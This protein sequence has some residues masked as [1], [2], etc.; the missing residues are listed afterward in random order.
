LGHALYRGQQIF[1]IFGT[2]GRYA[3]NLRGSFVENV[4]KSKFNPGGGVM[5]IFTL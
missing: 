3:T 4:K 5:A 1:A 2:F